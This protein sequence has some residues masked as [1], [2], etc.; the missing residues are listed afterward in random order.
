VES[1]ATTPN[2]ASLF[3]MSAS[4]DQPAADG[5]C[6]FL[7]LPAELRNAIYA[8]YLHR[9]EPLEFLR[10]S[11]DKVR[12][13]YAKA[14]ARKG[15][16]GDDPRE[17]RGSKHEVNQLR[18]VNKQLYTETR[19]LTI[20]GNELAFQSVRDVNFF[21]QHCKLELLSRIRCLHV[22][23]IHLSSRHFSE[24]IL[25]AILHFGRQDPKV[26]VKA[27]FDGGA[28]SIHELMVAIQAMM[29]E[30]HMKQSSRLLR[31]LFINERHEFRI[32]KMQRYSGYFLRDL[33][34]KP[35]KPI[36]IPPNLRFYPRAEEYDQ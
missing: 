24:Q 14:L 21:L 28:L 3:I 33:D 27:Y 10:D 35:L 2:I 18:F 20:C 11:N 22:H 32:A 30:L 16:E 29:W 12:R 25:S 4:P 6:H 23:G 26:Q 36:P 15:R 34:N 8:F 13:L 5:K 7:S 1:F 9:D 17:L 19:G 31:M